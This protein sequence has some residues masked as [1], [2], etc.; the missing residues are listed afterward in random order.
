VGVETCFRKLKREIAFKGL[1]VIDGNVLD[2]FKRKNG[3]YNLNDYLREELGELGFYDEIFSWD[4]VS[5]TYS[6]Q[7]SKLDLPDAGEGTPEAD[8]ADE[9][10]DELDEEFGGS[11]NTDQIVKEA[12]FNEFCRVIFKNISNP[13]RKYAFIV[14]FSD[15]IFTEHMT[16]QG[17]RDNLTLL[18]KAIKERKLNYSHENLGSSIIFITNNISKLPIALYQGNPDANLIT[19]PKPDRL[20][21]KEFIS[22]KSDFFYIKEDI[23]DEAVKEKLVDHTDEF[24]TK[25]LIQ[26]GMLSHNEKG[27]A[28]E[29]L[30]MLYKYGESESEWEKLTSEKVR[31]LK[32][33]LEKRVKGQ[34]DAIEKIYNVVVR[35]KTGLAGLQHSKNKS[36]PKGTLFFS[37]PT[38]VGKTEL[39]KS[40]AEFIFGDETACVRFDMSEYSQEHSDQKLIGAPPGYVGYE[41]G[42]VLIN[43]IKERP[44]CVLLFDEIEKAHSKILDKFLQILEDGRLTDNKGE[45]VYFSETIIV[46]TSNIG[47]NDIK[48][49]EEYETVKKKFIERVRDKFH[50]INRPELL[51]RIGYNNI[52]PFNFIK[53]SQIQ[54]DIAK[55]KLKPLKNYLEERYK[56]KLVFKSDDIED[57]IFDYLI[58]KADPN[59]GG[60]DVL[61][62]IETYFV[63]ELSNFIF[64]EEDVL[65]SGCSIYP[66][67]SDNKIKFTEDEADV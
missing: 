16:D 43:T 7:V 48:H 1:T 12:D 10:K 6:G 65:Y 8:E 37:G 53:D 26:L 11:D 20:E 31:G 33:V 27:I 58:G 24:T 51:G 9:L 45:T 64:E 39:A 19:I 23:D 52:V 38:G 13:D 22:Y 60:R 40:L 47:A 34:D 21:R 2:L 18:L 57:R 42:G 25:E 46:F 35:A 4:S 14:N 36:K 28:L 5:G 59:K 66:F 54:K 50:E 49:D 67:L 29:K 62:C 32:A 63:N 55:I 61:N 30:M 44:F 3:F 41:A 17:E 15:F 56:Y